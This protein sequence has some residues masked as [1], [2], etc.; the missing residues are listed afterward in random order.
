[1]NQFLEPVVMGTV[2]LPDEYLGSI[3]Q[4]CEVHVIVFLTVQKGLLCTLT[5]HHSCVKIG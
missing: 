4:L 5:D 1:M 3:L 2:V